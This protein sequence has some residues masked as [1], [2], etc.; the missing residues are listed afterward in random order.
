M[1]ARTPAARATTRATAAKSAAAPKGPPKKAAAATPTV[2]APVDPAPVGPPKEG[3]LDQ[4]LR[5]MALKAKR[6]EFHAVPAKV[7]PGAEPDATGGEAGAD[8]ESEDGDGPDKEPAVAKKEEQADAQEEEAAAEEPDLKRPKFVRQN[9]HEVLPGT[10]AND[11]REGR[12]PDADPPPGESAKQW[13][14][15][16]R[17]DMQAYNA[18]YYRLS[19]QGAEKKSE[20]QQIQHAGTGVDAAKFVNSIMDKNLKTSSDFNQNLDR[21]DDL[22]EWTTFKKALQKYDE[23]VLLAM[24]RSKSLEIQRDPQ[25]PEA[26][27]I[28]FPK[29]LQVRLRSQRELTRKDRGRTIEDKTEVDDA[30]Y[31]AQ[32]LANAAPT[33]TTGHRSANV[34]PAPAGE[35]TT[36]KKDA[37]KMPEAVQLAVKGARLT[38]QACDKFKRD[39]GVALMISKGN[40]NSKGCKLETDLEALV[41]T[42]Q[43]GDQKVLKFEQDCVASNGREVTNADIQE[44]GAECT[45][46]DKEIKGG[47]QKMAALKSLWKLPS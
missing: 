25:I 4:C 21:Q 31:E 35:P 9:T 28:P 6:G 7:E 17:K 34:Q 46:L 22:H 14:K 47:R 3:P 42:L 16:W 23:D 43:H 8:E 44:A 37:E 27:G 29:Y 41:A 11:E 20:W 36:D 12:A 18:F 38:H 5:N 40:P 2:A 33:Q 24:I 1:V 45:K 32:I 15:T 39:I 30:E 19:K 10:S 13:L 26:L